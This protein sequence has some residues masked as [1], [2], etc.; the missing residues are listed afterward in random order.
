MLSNDTQIDE[1]LQTGFETIVQAFE[2]KTTSIQNILNEN[3][4]KIADLEQQIKLYKEEITLLKQENTFIKNENKQLQEENSKLTSSLQASQSK[5]K[6]IQQSFQDEDNK[7]YFPPYKTHSNDK[8]S[9]ERGTSSDNRI[10]HTTNVPNLDLGRYDYRNVHYRH[11]KN[12]LGYHTSHNSSGNIIKGIHDKNNT[13]IGDSVGSH[14]PLNRQSFTSLNN[15]CSYNKYNYREEI[16]PNVKDNYF[17]RRSIDVSNNYMNDSKSYFQQKQQEQVEDLQKSSFSKTA[18]QGNIINKFL[19]SC[20]EIL[21]PYSFNL[22]VD[23]FQDYKDGLINDNELINKTKDV[24]SVS[25]RLTKLFDE[26]FLDEND[27]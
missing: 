3:S 8:Q 4:S 2:L 11:N 25:Y 19:N 9:S 22:I 27:E 14:T 1:L 16:I 6:K 13:K 17:K 18:S 24:V 15:N 10:L 7:E 20:K 5:L 12:P 21:S 23:I 26:L